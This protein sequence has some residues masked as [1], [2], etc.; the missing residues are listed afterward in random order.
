MSTSIFNPFFIFPILAAFLAPAT[1]E[2]TDLAELNSKLDSIK[3]KYVP[4]SRLAL[5]ERDEDVD[6]KVA[7]VRTTSPEARDAL[8]ELDKEIPDWTIRV[9]LFPEENPKLGGK[10]RALVNFSAIQL[11]KKPDYG[12]EWG[13]QSVMGTPVRIIDRTDGWVLI[14]N[15]DGYLGYT[16]AGSVAPLTKEEYDA[17]LASA[18]LVATESRSWIY[19][20]PSRESGIVS[21]L[22]AGC[23]VVW[24]NKET[25]DGF[26]RVETPDGRLGWIPE[27]E[28]TE[29]GEWLATRE[30]NA[31]N[32]I[33]TAR[34][35]L[36]SPYVWGGATTNGV[37]CSGLVSLSFRL[38][39]WTILRDVSQIRREG[40]D[41]DISNGW[42][43]FQPGDLL[44]FG[45]KRKDGSISWRHVG[46]Y[47]GEGRFVHSATSVHENSLDPDSPIYDARNA[48]EL[49][50]VVRMIGAPKTE[51]YRP[52]G[53]NQFFQM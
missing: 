28:A 10:W 23:V 18:R 27:S 31:E 3:E 24:K 25:R 36:G 34:R 51:H 7:S 37:D 32:L 14:Q 40:I 12:S 21:D 17:W 29:W 8:L 2:A 1:V 48:K 26:Y 15:F 53:E 52:I 30:L 11:Q 46:I 4:D 13:T 16:F 33:A 20:E 45:S 9:A 38:N 39:G 42:R 19:A 41:V 50:K 44:I 6:A 35:F 22:T 43:A 47:I 5:F 49:I